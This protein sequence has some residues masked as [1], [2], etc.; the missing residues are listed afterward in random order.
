MRMSRQPAQ[1]G[2]GEATA[3][4]LLART[5]FISRGLA[6]TMGP[7]DVGARHDAPLHLQRKKGGR[8]ARPYAFTL[9][10]HAQ[11][12]AR[13]ALRLQVGNVLGDVFEFVSDLRKDLGSVLAPVYL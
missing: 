1:C 2:R 7:F 8:P 13:L 10:E 5:T 4:W 11:N 3:S 6:P 9:A 12:L